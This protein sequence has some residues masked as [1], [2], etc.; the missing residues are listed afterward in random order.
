MDRASW[1]DIT[2][3]F[4]AWFFYGCT[5]IGG[6]LATHP[7]KV[8]ALSR[9]TTLDFLNNASSDDALKMHKFVSLHL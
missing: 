6:M 9:G 2:V 7:R 1:D 4:E 8:T 5:H 3:A